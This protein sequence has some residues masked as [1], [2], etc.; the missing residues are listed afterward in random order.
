[1]VD[2]GFRIMFSLYILFCV[3]D[4]VIPRGS[5]VTGHVWP[6]N[7]FMCSAYIFVIFFTLYNEKKLLSNCMLRTI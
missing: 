1:M 5:Q 3:G 4:N 2:R 6:A 7:M